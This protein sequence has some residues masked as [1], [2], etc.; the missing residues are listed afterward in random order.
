MTGRL[1]ISVELL[2]SAEIRECFPRSV[3]LGSLERPVVARPS[4][5]PE[6]VESDTITA[7]ICTS[8][9]CNGFQ[10]DSTPHPP[11]LPAPAPLSAPPPATS[12]APRLLCHQCGALFSTDGNPDCEQF[13]PGDPG[14]QGYC[15]AGEVCTALL[16]WSGGVCALCRCVC[17]TAGSRA[18]GGWAG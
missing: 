8:D 4:C 15:G 6:L 10:S 5:R 18:G 9:L 16:S 1:W 11:A 12:P 7:C 17:C 2:C 3:L 13:L 14:Q